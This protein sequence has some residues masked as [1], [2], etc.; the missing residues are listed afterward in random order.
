MSEIF[1]IKDSQHGRSRADVCFR[2]QWKKKVA[3]YVLMES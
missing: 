2:C 3:K 1:H